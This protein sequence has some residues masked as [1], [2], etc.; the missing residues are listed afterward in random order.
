MDRF[1]DWEHLHSPESEAYS[2]ERT[3]GLEIEWLLLDVGIYL[4]DG[5][6]PNPFLHHSSC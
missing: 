2:L 3:R 5:C 6:F 1:V 4:R